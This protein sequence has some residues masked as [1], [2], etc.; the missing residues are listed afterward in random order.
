MPQRVVYRVVGGDYFD[1]MD[2]P[3]L[4]GRAFS[5]SD[6]A[7]APG[8]VVINRA[9]AETYWPNQNPIGRQLTI[10]RQGNRPV[11]TRTVVG[12]VEV[13]NHWSVQQ[14]E[15]RAGMYVPAVQEGFQRRQTHFLVRTAAAPMSLAPEVQRVVAGIDP[16]QFVARVYPMHQLVEIWTD[17]PRFYTALTVVFAAVALVLSLIGI[18]GVM[19]YSVVQRTHEIG[20][21]M[22][23]GARRAQIVGL[24]AG[25]GLLLGAGGVAL[26]MTG[27]F[28][29][30][31]LIRP[32]GASSED[33]D[34]TSYSASAPRT[35]P[36]LPRSRC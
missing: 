25:R 27:A 2:I 5:E 16:G 14:L 10:P 30:T 6:S 34:G 7:Q 24:V 8:V 33:R 28:W 18:Y 29:L 11:S 22:A 23:L 17:G 1:V 36:P 35:Q 9:M 12:V 21:R 15:P 26:G 31:S 32:S 13:V 4:Q 3:L 20:I 19:A